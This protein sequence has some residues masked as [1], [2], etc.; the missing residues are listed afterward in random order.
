MTLVCL[1]CCRLRVRPRHGGHEK[2]CPRRP[3]P[4]C[5]SPR[6]CNPPCRHRRRPRRGPDRPRPGSPSLCS[7]SRR[8][9]GRAGP[10]ASRCSPPA[11]SPCRPAAEPGPGRGLAQSWNNKSFVN[12]GMRQY[13]CHSPVHYDALTGLIQGGHQLLIDDHLGHQGVDTVLFQ[14]K[15]FS[16][17]RLNYTV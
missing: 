6:S 14:L 11:G 8:P 1:P 2:S 5:G 16:K 3:C 13:C 12:T 17:D 15:C 9:R 4:G 7:A 10:A